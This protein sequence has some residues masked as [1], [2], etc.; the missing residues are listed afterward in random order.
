MQISISGDHLV[1]ATDL[2]EYVERRLSFALGRFAPAIA[3]VSVGVRDSNGPRGGNDKHCQ[4]VIKLRT[5][6][7]KSITVDDTDADLRAAVT[8]ASNRAGRCVARAIE[9][10]RSKRTYQRRRLITDVQSPIFAE[11]V[12]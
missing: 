5:A 4:I 8:R 3:H 11:T 10:R 6:G 7:S 1:G 9:R 12:T 2:G